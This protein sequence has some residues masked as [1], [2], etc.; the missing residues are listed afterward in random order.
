MPVLIYKLSKATEVWMWLC[1][2]CF[3]SKLKDGWELREKRSPPHELKCD[4]CNLG[5]TAQG[6]R[7]F[8]SVQTP[9]VGESR[10]PVAAPGHSI[11]P[12]SSTQE[13]EGVVSR[14]I[15][16]DPNQPGWEVR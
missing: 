7:G 3:K 4:S 15:R 6:A 12:S 2:G 16:R 13:G 8:S 10:K 14:S 5:T 9:V 1:G 11:L